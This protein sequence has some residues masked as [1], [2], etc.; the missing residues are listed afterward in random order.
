MVNP[1][2]VLSRATVRPRARFWHGHWRAPMKGV[3]GDGVI[4]PPKSVIARKPQADEA[5]Q[6]AARSSGAAGWLRPLDKLGT[7]AALL[8]I[9]IEPVRDFL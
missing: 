5:I 7:G 8:A 3:S 4:T 2:F 6:G 9:T 1:F